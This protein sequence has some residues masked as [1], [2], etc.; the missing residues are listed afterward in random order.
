TTIWSGSKDFAYWT[1]GDEKRWIRVPQK[2][3]SE[4]DKIIVTF[5]QSPSFDG[6]KTIML[7]GCFGESWT[8]T[9]LQGG[10]TNNAYIVGGRNEF[11]IV[12]YRDARKIIYTLAPDDA[13]RLNDHNGLAVYGC[14][15]KVTKVE[16]K[17]YRALQ[18]SVQSVDSTNG[19][20]LFEG[21][22]DFGNWGEHLG[23]NKDDIWIRLRYK[24]F[25]AGDQIQ[26]THQASD[27]CTYDASDI[28][29]Q[30][31]AR[32]GNWSST[33]LKGGTLANAYTLNGNGENIIP[34]SANQ[35]TA[36]VLTASDAKRLNDGNGLVVLAGGIKVT[37]IVAKTASPLV[38]DSGKN[39]WDEYST[40][41]DKDFFNGSLSFNKSFRNRSARHL[42]GLELAVAHDVYKEFKFVYTVN[43]SAN[44]ITISNVYEVVTTQQDEQ[45]FRADQNE[46]AG[47]GAFTAEY[48]LDRGD[49]K[50][51][52]KFN[53]IPNGVLSKY[54][55]PNV[56][57]KWTDNPEQL[58]RV[59]RISTQKNN[60]TTG[61][62]VVINV[63]FTNFRNIPSNV[64]L[65]VDNGGSGAT[66]SNGKITLSTRGLSL[67]SHSICVY[68]DNIFSNT[69]SIS[70]SEPQVVSPV[71][72]WNSSAKAFEGSVTWTAT[73][74]EDKV[75]LGLTTEGFNEE[76]FVEKVEWKAMSP[77]GDSIYA[78]SKSGNYSISRDYVLTASVRVDDFGQFADCGAL[79]WADVPGVALTVTIHFTTGRKVELAR[80]NGYG[81]CDEDYPTRIS[82]YL[83]TGRT[84][85][86]NYALLPWVDGGKVKI[87]SAVAYKRS[88]G[89]CST[90]EMD[91]TNS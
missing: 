17:T 57:Y 46:I 60:L 8:E 48:V 68:A 80:L 82:D 41:Y 47:I 49:G 56:Y 73:S 35:T 5:E 12:P 34:F 3:F 61:E 78:W 10:G 84:M 91:W 22:N 29:I 83:T 4:G 27:I 21:E 24:G 79:H 58:D 71:F 55:T 53:S 66:I 75:L 15:V 59:I 67:G 62:D 64:E 72:H 2:G 70:L 14:G 32:D 16:A 50:P 11:N 25:S 74:V 9:Y 77:K 86:A 52:L 20:V 69:I 40:S 26:I 30:M 37:K 36:Y 54:F 39:G 1:S 76:N 31:N 88:G 42:E 19:A 13:E 18:T 90:E 51:G 44:T 38:T 7:A 28:I 87:K 85:N 63:S 45:N 23:E 6:Y 89:P 81:G 43:S 65:I 33:R